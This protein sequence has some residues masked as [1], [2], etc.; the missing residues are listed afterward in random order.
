MDAIQVLWLI[1][2]VPMLHSS[3]TRAHTFLNICFIVMSLVAP[4]PYLTV[5]A[6]NLLKAS[7]YSEFC[8]RQMQKQVLSA[9]F[10]YSR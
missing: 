5:L 3:L 1:N 6:F 8:I 10:L 9:P 2:P 7:A 4:S